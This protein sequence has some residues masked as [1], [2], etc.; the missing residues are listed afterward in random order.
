MST[1]LA[2]RPAGQIISIPESKMDLPV[3]PQRGD[4]VTL[5]YNSAKEVIPSHIREDITWKQVVRDH[6]SER[7]VTSQSGSWPILW[8]KGLV[9]DINFPF[10]TIEAAF[11]H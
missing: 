7:A 1:N 10:F 6:A 11:Q 4:I 5:T 9:K 3:N 2:F 8:G